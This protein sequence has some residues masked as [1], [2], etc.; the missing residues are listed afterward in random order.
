M[1]ANLKSVCSLGHT[2]TYRASAV[3]CC[4][5]NIQGRVCVCVFSPKAC[6]STIIH[7]V[8]L[9]WRTT[10]AGLPQ[11]GSTSGLKASELWITPSIFS[12]PSHPTNKNNMLLQENCDV[13][14]RLHKHTHIHKH[15]W[16]LRVT[17]WVGGCQT[18]SLWDAGWRLRSW[19]EVRRWAVWE[20]VTS[21]WMELF[22]SSWSLHVNLIKSSPTQKCVFLFFMSLRM[23]D[24]D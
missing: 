10:H 12:P 3:Y 4:V 8:Y 5:I 17:L 13:T 6:C 18:D 2:I 1:T 9:I 7:P 16:G 21:P 19:R 20:R 22:V 11:F 14:L 15:T 24:F 23:S